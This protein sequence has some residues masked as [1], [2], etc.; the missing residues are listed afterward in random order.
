M[1]GMDNLDSLA[2][3]QFCGMHDQAQLQPS[4][5]RG[6]IKRHSKP[7][8]DFGELTA[9]RPRQAH[10]LTE[11]VQSESQLHAL[12]IG[13]ATGEQRIQL[14][15]ARVYLQ[16]SDPSLTTRT[17]QQVMEQIVA[18]CLRAVRS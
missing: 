4:L 12:I 2:P 1:M 14:Q 11:L 17:W 9:I 16:H 3:D 13:A 6:G 10:P 15:I 8:N 7:A 5:G 18:E